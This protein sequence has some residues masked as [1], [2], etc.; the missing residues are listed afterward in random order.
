MRAQVVPHLLAPIAC[1]FALGCS[2]ASHAPHASDDL[3]AGPDAPKA[4]APV[5]SCPKAEA[6]GQLCACIDL[7][8]ATSNTIY[9]LIDGS[10]S[11]NDSIVG[12][13]KW[14]LVRAALFDPGGAFRSVGTRISLGVSVMP[15]ASGRCDSGEQ[16]LPIT[17]G[18]D[19]TF[20]G[21][22]QSLAARTP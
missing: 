6:D 12:T 16:I 19:A 9:M 8:A 2:A 14:A 11:M 4:P 3:D 20:D 13:T 18:G 21:L 17:L 22:S 1:A 10:S 5:S 7:E 15:A